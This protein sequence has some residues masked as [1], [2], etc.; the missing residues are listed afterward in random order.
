MLRE[1]G[2]GIADGVALEHVVALVVMAVQDFEGVKQ[3]GIALAQN[4]GSSA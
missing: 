3:P 4:G 1:F 2:P